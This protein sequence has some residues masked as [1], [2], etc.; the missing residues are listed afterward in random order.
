[1]R[2]RRRFGGG[3]RRGVK[4]PVSWFRDTAFLR[5]A[6]AF[7]AAQAIT[8][9]DPEAVVFGNVDT[10]ITTRRLKA[11]VMP[12]IV[13]TAAVAQPLVCSWG[14]YVADPGLTVARD[15]ALA[16][17]EDQETDWLY[18]TRFPFT[19]AAVAAAT[20]IVPSISVP[21]RGSSW[22]G[23]SADIRA[24]RKLDNQQIL[25]LSWNFTQLDITDFAAPTE[26]FSG[27]KAF[28]STLYSRTM[29]R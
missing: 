2:T 12:F 22:D 1:M 27:V 15:P 7:G 19:I 23:F 8:Y 10:R 11:E 17:E 14:I 4:E 16:T 18:L 5:T 26:T 13:L 24:M 25:A 28:R 29:R 21:I 3:F 9:F 6:S 20:A